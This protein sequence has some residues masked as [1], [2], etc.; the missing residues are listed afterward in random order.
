MKRKIIFKRRRCCCCSSLCS[1]LHFYFLM[2]TSTL[3]AFTPLFALRGSNS[4]AALHIA[5]VSFFLP[6]GYSLKM[7][8]RYNHPSPLL[9]LRLIAPKQQHRAKTKG[10]DS[11]VYAVHICIKSFFTTLVVHSASAPSERS[12]YNILKGAKIRSIFE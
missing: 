6:M 11:D 7:V 9:P 12:V 8:H 3:D 5:A 4:M 10:C 1:L 2:K